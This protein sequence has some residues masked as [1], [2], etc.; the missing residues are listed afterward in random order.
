VPKKN[1]VKFKKLPTLPHDVYQINNNLS[2]CFI[3]V[4]YVVKA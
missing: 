3:N 2:L 4:F 1:P